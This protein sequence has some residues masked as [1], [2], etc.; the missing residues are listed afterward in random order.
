MKYFEKVESLEDL[1]AQ[2]RTLARKNHPDAGGDPEAMKAINAEFD[3][4]FPIWKNRFNET[5]VKA[6]KETAETV[7]SEFYTQC[8]WKGSKNDRSRSTKEVT[9]L[10]RAYVKENYPT[11]KFSVRFSQASMCSEVHIEMK[12]A[13]Q[14]I[15]KTFDQLS[16]DE[17]VSVWSKAEYNYWVPKTGILD[18]QMMQEVEKAYNEHSFLK[19]Y[20]DLAQHVIEDIDSEVKSYNYS[21]CDGMIDYFDVDFWWFGVKTDNVKIVPKTAR[22]QKKQAAKKAPE[23]HTEVPEQKTASLEQEYEIK[24]DVHTKTG[25]KIFTVKVVRKLSREEYLSVAEKMKMLGGYYSRFKHAF[26]FHE[27]PTESLVAA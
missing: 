17:V 4:L 10:V 20:T 7:R 16:E 8:G 15:Y 23:S 19:I 2:Y 24:K 6:T 21:D 18:E 5:A 14:E 25:E 11:W 22:I 9:A 26:V 13:P 3:E 12:E 27:D 1:K